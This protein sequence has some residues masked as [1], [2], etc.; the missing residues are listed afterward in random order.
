VKNNGIVA[1]FSAAPGFTALRYWKN[2]DTD[3]R[4]YVE[5]RPIVGWALT[6]VGDLFEVV[7]LCP[8]DDVVLGVEGG[9]EWDIEYPDGRV[10]EPYGKTYTSRNAWMTEKRAEGS[11]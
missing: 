7:P 1:V 3:R 2:A 5:H 10:N 11:R 6:R 8:G 9:V 4:P